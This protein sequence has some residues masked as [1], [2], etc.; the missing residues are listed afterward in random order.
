M[1]KN[2]RKKTDKFEDTKYNILEAT[3]WATYIAWRSTRGFKSHP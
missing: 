1:H 3:A 2:K